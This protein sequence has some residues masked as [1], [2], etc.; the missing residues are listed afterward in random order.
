[1]FAKHIRGQSINVKILLL[2]LLVL[3]VCI[4]MSI[5]NKQ[6]IYVTFGVTLL[7]ILLNLNQ[8]VFCQLFF[9][10]PFTVIY[11]TSPESSSFFA[12]LLLISAINIIAREKANLIYLIPIGIYLLIGLLNKPDLWLKLMAGWVL[13]SY[14]VHNADIDKVK[15]ISLSFA[16]GIIFSSLWGLVKFDIPQLAI[17]IND[18]NGEYM[19]GERIDRFCGLYY[20]PN[21]YA[22]SVI[23]AL[24]MML[25][26][27]ALG[28]IDKRIAFPL[29]AILLYFG[30][31]TYS[32]MFMLAA[33][34]TILTQLNNVIRYSKNKFIVFLVL[35]VIA[36]IAIPRFIESSFV[37]H[38]S[39]RFQTRDLTS[40]RF[41]LVSSY[42]TYIFSNIDI[43]FLGKGLGGELYGTHGPHNTFVESLYYLGL[44]GTT[45]YTMTI[46]KIFSKNRLITRRTPKNYVLVAIF[47][48]LL[49]SLGLLIMNDLMF[50]FIIVWYSLNID[51]NKKCYN[52]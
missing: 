26:L 41:D 12:Y 40:G 36:I 8:Y 48:V 32:K 21:Y 10:I 3:L 25:N 43:L 34:L 14:F 6:F 30:A 23:M 2:Q 22:V 42:L 31:M 44:I 11:K 15:Y 28:K 7:T 35:V 39:D 13:M 20:D 49:S 19:L 46:S 50:Y 47:C 33:L 45:I 38:F 29:S 52:E 18:T 5:F 16:L 27:G 37:A 9:L 24:F 1:M 51:Y 4:S 17:Y